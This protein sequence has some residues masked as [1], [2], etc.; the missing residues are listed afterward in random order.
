MFNPIST[1]ARRLLVVALLTGSSM[2]MAGPTYHVDLDSS[3]QSGSGY[4]VLDFLSTDPAPTAS[5]HISGWTGAFLGTG[6]PYTDETADFVARTLDLHSGLSGFL[7]DVGFGG[8]FGFDVSFD[9]DNVPV[10]ATFGAALSDAGGNYLSG[11]DLV[12]ITLS[13]DQPAALAVNA[14]YATVTAV[15]PASAVPEPSTLLSM[16]SGLGLLG[17]GLRRRRT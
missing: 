17:F 10:A 6:M 14:A 9:A 16:V 5:A 8:H 13:P 2:A 15:P 1:F 12:D 3:S 7:F 11:D 4:L